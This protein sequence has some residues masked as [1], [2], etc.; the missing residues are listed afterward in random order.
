MFGIPDFLFSAAR[1]LKD[2]HKTQRGSHKGA[3]P[4]SLV[5]YF[6]I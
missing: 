5:V 6:F 4:K 2:G 3:D 1:F